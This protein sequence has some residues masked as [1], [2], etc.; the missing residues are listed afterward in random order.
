MIEELA[1]V[2][3]YNYF[4]PTALP[5]TTSANI[6]N[7]NFL[8]KYSSYFISRG[9]HET[10]SFSFLPK[11]SQNNFIQPSK[12]IAIK[13]P[14]SEDK[15]ELRTSLIHSLI[16]TYKYNFSR[17][18]HDIKIFENG[19][20]YVNHNSDSMKEVNTIS[21]LISGKNYDSNLKV[22]TKDLSFL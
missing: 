19:N 3:G 7:N 8:E 22:D 6:G 14:I 4:K 21:G 17:Q 10:V 13:N 12:I 1:R 11:N 18:V 20:T 9:Y 15:S 2:V 5:V 16:K